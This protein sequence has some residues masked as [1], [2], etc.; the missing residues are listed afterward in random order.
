MSFIGSIL[1]II[2]FA[3][4]IL[5]GLSLGFLIFRHTESKDVKVPKDEC[6]ELKRLEKLVNKYERGLIHFEHQVV[7]QESSPN[8]LI[9]ASITSTNELVAVWDLEMG[10]INPSEHK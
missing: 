2:G 10:K 5:V 1:R 4:G 9:P 6:G 8:L 3:V 7:L